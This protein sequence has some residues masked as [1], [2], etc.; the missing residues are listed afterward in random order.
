MTD[1]NIILD[2][3]KLFGLEMNNI[4][5]ND[6]INWL[7]QKSQY[8]YCYMDFILINI[9]NLYSV[10][11]EHKERYYK[12]GYS[13]YDSFFITNKKINMIDKYYSNCYFV[14]D[15]RK[16]TGNEDELYYIKYDKKLFDTY[17]VDRYDR[18]LILKS[19]CKIN[20]KNLMDDMTGSIKNINLDLLNI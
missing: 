3:E 7:I 11:L 16:Q 12:T 19:D 5:N 20:F 8:K 17:E 15:F 10:Y 2:S 13:S 1:N 14:F 6:N 4:L 9:H 18:K